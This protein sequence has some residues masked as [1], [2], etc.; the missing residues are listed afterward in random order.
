MSED[1]KLRQRILTRWGTLKKEREPYMTQWLEISEHITPSRGRFLIGKNRNESRSRWNRIVDS[2]AVRAANILAAGLMSGMT[3]PSSQWFALTTGTPNLDE[4]QA[5]K[6][7]LDQVQ[8]IM[9]MAFTRTN[10]YQALH[11]GWRDVGTYGVMAMVIA[12]DD[13]EVFHCYPLSVGEY[14][15]G[16]DD[17]GVPDT[18]YRRFIMTAAQLVARFGRSKLS[19]DVLR[20]FDAGQVDHEYKLIH[21]IEPRFDRQYGKRDS[22]NMPWR[23]VIIQIDSDG[24]KDGILEE[25]G[26]NEFPCVVGR[27]GASASDVYS[28]ESPGMVALGDV[29]QLQHEQKQ[30]GNSIDYIVN[31][32]LIMPTAARDNEDDFEPGGRI[33]LDAPAQK[34]AV[35]SAWQVQMD[36][37]A[38]RQDIAEVQQRINQAFSVDMFL[39]LSGQQMGKMTATEVAERHEEK[40]MMLG[41]VLSRL[42]NE[43]LKPLIERTFSILYRA[44]Q[45]PPAPPELAGVELSIEYTSMLA[46]SQRAIR[47]NSLDQ[48]LQRIGQVAQFDPNVLAKIDSFRIVD[49]YAD[50]LSVAPSVVVPTEQAQQKIEAQQQAQQQ[51]EQMQQAADAVSK[52]GRVP[53]DGSTVGG[54]AV[55]GMQELAQQGAL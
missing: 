8:R 50:Y 22:R 23:S 13:R 33:Y 36:I 47:A 34:D 35:Q 3:D 45:L 14:A 16:V 40:L 51:A 38:L 21:A 30:K 10:T 26:F 4:A 17:R 2:S 31:P 15:I 39:M 53:A 52:L 32:P 24:T 25:S 7:W 54:Q 29:R 44:G 18:L 43:V 37:N 49:E 42:N 19:A 27:W 5:V 6:V 12:E 20:N 46:R 28:E 48:F 41:P 11:Q 55:Q 9:E 1:L